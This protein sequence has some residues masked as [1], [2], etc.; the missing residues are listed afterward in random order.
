M[1]IEVVEVDYGN[2]THGQHLFQL[3]NEYAGDPM[4]GGEPIAEEKQPEIVRGL[5]D[6]PTSFSLLVY[7]DGQPAALTNCF[8]G[9]STFAASKLINIHDLMVSKDFR[10]QGLS[11]LLL[12]S[13]EKKAKANGCCKLTLEVLSNNEVAKNSYKK[14]GF[15]GYELDPSA[16]EAIFWQ[17]KL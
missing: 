6:F 17:K 11:Q 8:F 16:G 10:G 1:S 4:G 15:E 7:V 13:V 3:L 2:E 5:A 9:F 12:E 14:Y